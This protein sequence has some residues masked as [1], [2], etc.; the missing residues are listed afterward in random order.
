MLERWYGQCVCFVFFLRPLL[1][2]LRVGRMRYS[3]PILGK[4]KI[5]SWP[6][7]DVKN[8]WHFYLLTLQSKLSLTELSSNPNNGFAAEVWVISRSYCKIPLKW[9]SEI[10]R[11][12]HKCFIITTFIQHCV[13]A[14]CRKLFIG[15]IVIFISHLT[16]IWVKNKF[17]SLKL[18]I[19]WFYK[20][21]I[22]L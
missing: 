4:S 6:M 16:L 9:P 17:L 1:F 20:L 14:L 5:T 12:S 2:P 13:N 3:I 15:L 22:V 11:R 21:K 7:Y 18:Y 8:V 10:Q 19:F